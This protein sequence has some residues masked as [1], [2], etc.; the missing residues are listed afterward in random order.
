MEEGM[1]GMNVHKAVVANK[2]RKETGIHYVNEHYDEGGVVFQKKVILSGSETPDIRRIHELEQVLPT[3]CRVVGI[4]IQNFISNSAYC[5]NL[6][7]HNE[8][9]RTYIY[10][11]C[12]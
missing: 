7:K 4:G 11:R 2:E 12:C 8:L 6:F 10:R 3:N 5:T 9:R 1:Y